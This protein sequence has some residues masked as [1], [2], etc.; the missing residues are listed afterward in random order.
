M[1]SQLLELFYGE[2]L[3]ES[4]LDK[5]NGRKIVKCCL[6]DTTDENNTCDSIN[7][8]LNRDT[9]VSTCIQFK[10][11]P[12]EINKICF[13]NLDSIDSAIDTICA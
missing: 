8:N 3:N 9:T 13:N 5:L 7:D 4:Q 10:F 12:A 6:I 1:V 2:P 11:S